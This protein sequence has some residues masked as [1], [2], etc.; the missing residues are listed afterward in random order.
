MDH[1]SFV[2]EQAWLKHV[3]SRDKLLNMFE[4][5]LKE[6]QARLKDSSTLA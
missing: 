6:V 5:L 3:R 4:L 1:R 2:P